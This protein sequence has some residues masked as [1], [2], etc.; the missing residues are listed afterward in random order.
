MPEIDPQ[1]IAHRL[2]VLTGEVGKIQKRRSFNPKR[3]LEINEEVTK[4]INIDFIREA[5]FAMGLK[6]GHGKEIQQKVV[7]LH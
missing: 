7:N 2:N 4:L 3:Y 1:I 6:C 5:N